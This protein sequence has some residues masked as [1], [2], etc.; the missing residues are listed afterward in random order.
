[1]S[2]PPIRLFGA[3]FCP[4]VTAT[5]QVF[6]YPQGEVLINITD[7]GLS[8]SR[9]ASYAS[10]KVA[11][12]ASNRL[13]GCPTTGLLTLTCSS[14]VESRVDERYRRVVPGRIVSAV[15]SRVMAQVLRVSVKAFGKGLREDYGAW[16]VGG[17]RVGV[18]D[19]A[20]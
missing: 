18:D 2:L 16:R 3:D 5:V 13:R 10:D 11:V 15:G 12:T 9:A 14:R 19:G 1:M 8:G 6:D 4:L 7:I 17:E 20:E